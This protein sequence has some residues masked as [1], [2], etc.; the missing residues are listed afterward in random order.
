MNVVD[1]I[2]L[3]SQA[4]AGNDSDHSLFANRSAAF[5]ALGL[6][7]KALWDA[8][9]AIALNPDWAKGYYRAGCA[10]ESLNEWEKASLA[11]RKAAELEPKDAL[12]KTKVESI[13]GKLQEDTSAKNAAAAVER[14]NLVLKLRE[15]RHQD[16]K[17]AM[18]NQ[19]KQSMTAPDWELEDLEW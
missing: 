3:Y 16:Q 13:S 8:Q 19:F 7:D 6:L 14:H 4:I 1:A 2:K 15:A 12:L 9:K 18:M 11:F 5:L 17:L 10:L